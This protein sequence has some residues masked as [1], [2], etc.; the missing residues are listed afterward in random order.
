MPTP[1]SGQQVHCRS[2]GSAGH[3]TVCTHDGALCWLPWCQQSQHQHQQWR[4]RGWRRRRM[5]TT[6]SVLVMPICSQYQAAA[7]HTFPRQAQA[8]RVSSCPPPHHANCFL[9]KSAAQLQL[10]K[11]RHIHTRN[12]I[13]I[14]TQLQSRRVRQQP[15]PATHSQQR[16]A[17]HCCALAGSVSGIAYPCCCH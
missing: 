13:H 8:S 6:H 4:Q 14:T 7:V 10:H 1:C 17:R 3:G 9:S 16:Q 5:Q 15:R 11:S 12:N 2:Y